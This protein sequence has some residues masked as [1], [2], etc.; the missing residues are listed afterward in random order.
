MILTAAAYTCHRG[1]LF[2]IYTLFT[3]YVNI[4]N[5]GHCLFTFN[6]V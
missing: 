5:L 3:S 6:M 1:S 4:Y 2:Y